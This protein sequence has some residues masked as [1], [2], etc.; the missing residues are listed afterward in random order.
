MAAIAWSNDNAS[1]YTRTITHTVHKRTH[2]RARAYREG[3]CLLTGE[4]GN[5]MR[6]G[7]EKAH[8]RVHTFVQHENKPV[9]PAHP[10]C[11]YEFLTN[12][13]SSSS[14]SCEEDRPYTK[15]L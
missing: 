14:S 2:V 12:S 15:G 10:W 5:D 3:L 13:C 9:D 1:A 8:N 7:A 11:V 4:Y 6:G